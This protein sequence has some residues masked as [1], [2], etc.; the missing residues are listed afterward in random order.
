M[1]V[2][3]W[4]WEDILISIETQKKCSKKKFACWVQA[5]VSHFS[6]GIELKEEKK[7]IS[8]NDIIC[9]STS[10]DYSSFH[11]A[12]W[13]RENAQTFLF[14]QVLL[15]CNLKVA[16]PLTSSKAS[17]LCYDELCSG[18]AKREFTNYQCRNFLFI[19]LE[20]VFIFCWKFTLK[21][22]HSFKTFH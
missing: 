13:Q 10:R 19:L 18:N 21:A 7:D 1:H 5:V 14:Q 11:F 22:E 20:R 6:Y 3:S 17:Q 9:S 12:S 15:W 2:M 4:M 16:L 8:I